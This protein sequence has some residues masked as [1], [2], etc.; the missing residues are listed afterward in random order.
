MENTYTERINRTIKYEYLRRRNIDC[1]STLKKM[2]RAIKLSNTKRPHWSLRQ[3]MASAIFEVHV[4]NLSKT[5]RPEMM[6]YKPVE[7]LSHKMNVNSKKEKRSK[8]EKSNNS[9]NISL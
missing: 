9:N 1:L 5:R 8:K 3:Q 4:N 6:I 7:M 2:G